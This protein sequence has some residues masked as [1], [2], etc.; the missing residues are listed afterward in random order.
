M[1]EGMFDIGNVTTLFNIYTADITPPRAL[2]QVMAYADDITITST[3]TGTSQEIHTTI[4]T[5]IFAYAKHNNVTLN[6]DKT[7]STPEHSEYKG[8]LDLK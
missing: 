6:S 8:N 2:V 5:Y 3:H 4:P 7:N 1:V